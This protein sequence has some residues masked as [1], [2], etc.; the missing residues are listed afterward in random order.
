MGKEASVASHLLLVF[1]ILSRAL[2]MYLALLLL[3]GAAVQARESVAIIS[4]GRSG[5]TL[6]MNL[7]GAVPETVFLFEPYFSISHHDT[8]VEKLP[9][10]SH[11]I[12]RMEHLFDCSFA[13]WHDQLR[14][15]LSQF[16]C[17]NTPWLAETAQEVADCRAFV[18]NIQRTHK[19]CTSANMMV[20]KILKLPWLARKLET[21]RVIPEAALVIHLVRRPAA[22]L[23]SQHAAGWV[24]L[25]KASAGVSPAFALAGEI[26]SEM[27][28][29]TEILE[30]HPSDRV[31]LIHYEEL[32]GNFD[33][34]MKRV[35][36]FVHVEPSVELI[37]HLASVRE[38]LHA[39]IPRY[40]GKV[41]TSSAAQAIV[42]AQPL[43]RPV[44]SQLYSRDEL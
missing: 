33:A 12:P 37:A 1:S 22:V 6:L 34:T 7:L 24:D 17:D 39:N 18:F 25:V 32:I 19:R 3:C 27:T 28:S 10:R 26:C 4:T 14:N 41:L 5:S 11:L 35:L 30:T 8:E 15:V 44:D 43:C 13:M 2:A 21:K 38:K 9:A 16:A 31:L 42:D 29:N 20:L 23:A 40:R 36:Q